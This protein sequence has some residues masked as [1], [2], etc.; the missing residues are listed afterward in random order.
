[1][2]SPAVHVPLALRVAIGGLS[3]LLAF[4]AA[5]VGVRALDGNALPNLAIFEVEGGTIQLRGN[6]CQDLRRPDGRVYAVCTDADGARAP[7]DG[8]WLIVGDSQ[9]L[10]LGVGGEETFAAQLGAAGYGV[11]G[12]GVVDTVAAAAR[13]VRARPPAGVILVLNQANDWDEGERRIHERYAVRGGWLLGVKTADDLGARFWSSPLSSSHLCF[14]VFQRLH[15]SPAAE[16]V[17]GLGPAA[18]VHAR[19]AAFGAHIAAFAH[20]HPQLRTLAA[21]L[22]ADAATSEARAA[23]SPLPWDGRPW[24][25]TALRD[26]LRDTLEDVPLVDLVEPLRAPENFLQGDFHLSEAG[27]RRVAEALRGPMSASTAP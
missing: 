2:G 12:Y 21:F 17:V 23:V 25:D 5:E 4:L 1:M 9:V 14:Q 16:P 26:D 20:A 24:A 6:A 27:H 18:A 13:L 15:P 8:G 10:G 22:P 11:P 19:T 3:T 7:S